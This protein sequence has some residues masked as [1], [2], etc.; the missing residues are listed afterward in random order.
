MGYL[1]VY[2]SD[3]CSRKAAKLRSR[4]R[5]KLIVK[6]VELKPCDNCGTP[7]AR[8]NATGPINKLCAT[9]YTAKE[10]MRKRAFNLANRQR[11][12]DLAN[13]RNQEKR[14]AYLDA[15]KEKIQ[16]KKTIAKEKSLAL[17]DA[18]VKANP[19]K[20]RFYKERGAPKRR[21]RARAYHAKY[22]TSLRDPYIKH[23][24]VQ[25]TTIS[26]K[27]VPQSLIDLKRVQVQITR[28]LKEL[29]K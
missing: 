26:K 10:K 11:L 16:R 23:L 24:L 28:A 25:G 17:R 20:I 19:E 4:A 27:S 3:A 12:L 8:I 5:K 18:W 7:I 13:A 15:N 14:R 1:K 21:E 2:C 29:N 22:S 9:C 6:K